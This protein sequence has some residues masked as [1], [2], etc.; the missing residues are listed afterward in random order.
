MVVTVLLFVIACGQAPPT[1]KS[2]TAS[3]VATSA[4]PTAPATSAPSPK[5]TTTAAAPAGV[6]FAGKTITM[7]VPSS[8]G[9]GSDIVVRLWARYFSKYLPGNPSIIVRNMVGGAGTLGG[10]HGYAA[11][12]DGLTMTQV[13]GQTAISYMTG[14]SAVKY[15]LTKVDSIISQASGA[16]FYARP[17]IV[18]KLEEINKNQ[19]I[20]FGASPGGIGYMFALSVEVLGIP[21]KKVILAYGGSADAR[22]AYM[23]GEVNTSGE[24][25]A[26]WGNV[27]PMVEKNEAVNLF[28]TG[29]LEGGKLVRD[30]NMPPVPT[31]GELYEKIYGKAPS[32][33][34]SDAYKAVLATTRGYA[35]VLVAPPGTP[36]AIIKVYWDAAEKMLKDPAYNKDLAPVV[37]EKGAWQAGKAL[38]DAYK[39]AMK[40]DPKVIE[41][42]KKTFS[43]K[44]KVVLE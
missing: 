4:K 20:I 31:T 22:R 29:I 9:G 44:Y 40:L 5:P 35:K 7:I 19:D 21:A 32:G 3:P 30:P 27:V 43:E 34:V 2:T 25:E 23:S 36:E 8:P 37:G 6:S 1:P 13:A 38:S 15:D 12:P 17:G 39:V 10:N 16:V 24:G 28:Q 11:R 26:Y 14:M 33:M 42:T 18:P 41:W